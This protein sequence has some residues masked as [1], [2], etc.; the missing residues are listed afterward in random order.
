MKDLAPVLLVIFFCA[1]LPAIAARF[2][3]FKDKSS[4]S[5]KL[6]TYSSNSLLI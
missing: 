5:L 4:C 1:G 6:T 2:T 3:A